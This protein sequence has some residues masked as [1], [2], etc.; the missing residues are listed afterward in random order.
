MKKLIFILILVIVISPLFAQEQ[1]DERMFGD[2]TS[3]VF[4]IKVH[5][6]RIIMAGTGYLVQY[7]MLSSPRLGIVGIPFSW[8]TH[9]SARAEMVN[10]PR[11]PSMPSMSIFFRNGEF[12]FVRLHV[13]RNRSHRTW[14]VT[15]Q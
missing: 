8:F 13:H 4:Y 2:Q 6:E 15:P 9:A 10:L 7:R 12:D 1:E 3:D 11:G 14:S 5:V